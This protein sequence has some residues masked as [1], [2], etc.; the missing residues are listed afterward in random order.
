MQLGQPC[1]KVFTKTRNGTVCRSRILLNKNGTLRNGNYG[2]KMIIVE[3]NGPLHNAASKRDTVML[4]SSVIV[5]RPDAHARPI[6]GKNP[7]LI[8]TWGYLSSL[9]QVN[10]SSNI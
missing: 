3:R 1:S 10:L 9:N 8:A 4:L 2:T 5:Y 6:E 7:Q